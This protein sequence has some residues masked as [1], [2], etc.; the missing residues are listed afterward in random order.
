MIS[1]TAGLEST[2][3]GENLKEVRRT[4]R[5]VG[6]GFGENVHKPFAWTARS[7]AH[8]ER[9]VTCDAL[10]RECDEEPDKAISGVGDRQV[11][12]ADLA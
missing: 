8:P 4:K 11:R 3:N 1:Q 2:F 9:R 6:F 12:G 10:G 7:G 5:R